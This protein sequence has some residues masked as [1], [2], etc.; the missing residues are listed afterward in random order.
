MRLVVATPSTIAP[1]V[2]GRAVLPAIRPVVQTAVAGV[3]H[4]VT[5]QSWLGGHHRQPNGNHRQTDDEGT[6]RKHAGHG[7]PPK[8]TATDK[9][10]KLP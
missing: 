2:T 4:V 5:G 1:T 9:T 10:G 7:T 3:F 8:R 6:Y